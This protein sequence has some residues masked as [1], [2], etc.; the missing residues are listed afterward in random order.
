MLEAVRLAVR[1]IFDENPAGLSLKEIA[2]R[3]DCSAALLYSWADLGEGGADIPL[4]R[5][6]QL[7]LITGDGRALAALGLATHYFVLPMPALGTVG[8]LEPES[9]RALHEFSEFMRENARAVI[10]RVMAAGDLRRI[11]KEGYEAMLAIARVIAVARRQR[12]AAGR[13]A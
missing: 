11:E 9:I 5:L 12:Q 10:A 13:K 2:L 3:M 8:E 4:K 1:E 7:T 6:V